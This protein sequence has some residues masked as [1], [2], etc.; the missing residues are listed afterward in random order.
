MYTAR[1]NAHNTF[2]NELNAEE[3]TIAA[4]RRLLAAGNVTRNSN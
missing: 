4:A 3:S 2:I 1:V